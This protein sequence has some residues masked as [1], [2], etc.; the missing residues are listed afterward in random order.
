VQGGV[1]G[2]DAGWAF[3]AGGRAAEPVKP[4]LGVREPVDAYR[5]GQKCCPHKELRAAA[6]RITSGGSTSRASAT[7]EAVLPEGREPATSTF[8]VKPNGVR[9]FGMALLT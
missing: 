2:P 7:P 4:S 3:F 9:H 8:G 6:R 1:G 5:K